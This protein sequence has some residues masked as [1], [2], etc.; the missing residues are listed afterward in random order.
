ML[1]AVLL[2]AAPA[3]PAAAQIPEGY[4][5]TAIIRGPWCQFDPWFGFLAPT[6]ASAI[7]DDGNAVVGSY[8]VCASTDVAYI[9]T[10]GGMHTLPWPQNATETYANDIEGPKVVGSYYGTDSR[11]HAVL[12]N[13]QQILELG[14]MPGGNGSQASAIAEGR[15]VGEWGGP[16]IHAFLWEDGVMTDLALPMGPNSSASDVSA[17]GAIVG[18]MGNFLTDAHAFLSHEVTTDLGVVPGGTTAYAQAI[19]SWGHVAGYGAVPDDNNQFGAPRAFFWDGQRILNLGTLLGHSSSSASDL[20]DHAVVVGKS[21]GTGFVWH[22][23]VMMDLRDLVVDLPPEI[24]IETANGINN[25]GQIVCTAKESLWSV[26]LLL[27]P[28]EEPTADLDCDGVVGWEDF[29][30]LL[31]AWG[32]CPAQGLCRADLDQ[33]GWVGVD[34]FLALLADWAEQASRPENERRWTRNP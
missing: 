21:G 27:T 12:W 15:I 26:G 17:S 30:A 19:N 34:D 13:G 24:T 2:A 8:R 28:I 1:A 9:W 18:W 25:C 23:G 29:V 22:D 6:S 3:G 5:V 20:N 33:N 16:G 4:T 14:T 7:S 10:F 32:P 11:F 31:D